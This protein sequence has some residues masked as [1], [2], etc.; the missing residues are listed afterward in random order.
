MDSGDHGAATPWLLDPWGPSW[1]S[2]NQPSTA[3][4][5]VQ[6]VNCS[7]HPWPQPK[8]KDLDP[9]TVSCRYPWALAPAC[10]CAHTCMGTRNAHVCLDSVHACTCVCVYVCVCV[11]VCIHSGRHGPSYLYINIPQ[12][13]HMGTFVSAGFRGH[14]PAHS[15]C[16]YLHVNTALGIPVPS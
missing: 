10:M 15:L 5:L 9:Q 4:G 3:E 12:Q 14:P 16:M 7:W 11:C 8:G 1:T 6:I 13:I 2:E